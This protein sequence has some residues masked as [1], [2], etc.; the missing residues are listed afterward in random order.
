MVEN[1]GYSPKDLHFEDKGRK[2]L[3]NGVQKW[4]SL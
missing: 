3:A 1:Q 4:L 2:K